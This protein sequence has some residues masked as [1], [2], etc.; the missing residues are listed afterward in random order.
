MLN[1][2]YNLEKILLLLKSDRTYLE[3]FLNNTLSF[4]D[5]LL[6]DPILEYLAENA[7]IVYGPSYGVL[8]GSLCIFASKDF[9]PAK[10]T[11]LPLHVVSVNGA[12]SIYETESQQDVFMKVALRNADS[13]EVEAIALKVIRDYVP[14]EL[15]RFFLSYSASCSSIV[16][17]EPITDALTLDLAKYTS[18]DHHENFFGELCTNMPNIVVSPTIFTNVVESGISLD[19]IIQAWSGTKTTLL[20][21]KLKQLQQSMRI[22][23]K[24]S[25]FD[26]AYDQVILEKRII[27]AVWVRLQEKLNEFIVALL[28]GCMPLKF[29]HGD[30]HSG[31][32]LFNSLTDN[33]VMIDYGR[34]CID[35]E[36]IGFSKQEILNECA[37]IHSKDPAF[38]ESELEN[39]N[40][41]YELYTNH[42]TRLTFDNDKISIYNILLDLAPLMYYVYFCLKGRLSLNDH[43]IIAYSPVSDKISVPSWDDQKAYFSSNTDASPFDL[44]LAYLSLIIRAAQQA[45]IL[46]V[47]LSSDTNSSFVVD[48]DKVFCKRGIFYTFGQPNAI[49]FAR[50]K[51]ELMRLTSEVDYFTFVKT[52]ISKKVI[53]AGNVKNKVKYITNEMVSS[54]TK[55]NYVDN[56]TQNVFKSVTYDQACQESL[57]HTLLPYKFKLTS[58]SAYKENTRKNNAKK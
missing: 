34:S 33:F 48:H 29:S 46:D 11:L 24:S 12:F 53:R 44:C 40:Q 17:R 42:G 6:K 49:A 4:Q 19:D 50:Y 5:S 27:N 13:L 30:L 32:V 41:F 10:T 8:I 3:K 7:L 23:H 18:T 26:R 43:D 16:Y 31:N 35:L 56:L 36:N 52:V 22:F 58:D 14:Q 20:P 28:Q 9:V 21:N 39:P 55:Q 2:T 45:R 57:E 25:V 54:L 15:K 38:I 1:N 51:K 37:K 47:E